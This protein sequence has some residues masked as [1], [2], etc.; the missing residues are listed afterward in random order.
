LVLNFLWD[1]V[2]TGLWRHSRQASILYAKEREYSH[3]AILQP[4]CKALGQI[5]K[6][7][8]TFYQA[9]K[10]TKEG[11]LLDPSTF[12]KYRGRHSQFEK[13]WASAKNIRRSTV[14][15]YLRKFIDALTEVDVRTV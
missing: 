11:P 2:G 6:G 3:W 5:Y 4:L 9:N 14:D 8:M 13:F 15:G 10:K 12:F 1:A 7:A